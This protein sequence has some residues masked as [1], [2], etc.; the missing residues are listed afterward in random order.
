MLFA[1]NTGSPYCIGGIIDVGVA[2]TGIRF[3]TDVGT[4]MCS[5]STVFGLVLRCLQAYVLLGYV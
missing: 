2:V 3:T 4:E 5:L 1:H